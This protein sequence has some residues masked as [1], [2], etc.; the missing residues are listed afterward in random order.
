[1]KNFVDVAH[2]YPHFIS[3]S[4]QFRYLVCLIA[5]CS[6]FQHLCMVKLLVYLY[7]VLCGFRLP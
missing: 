5:W 3:T 4:T 7:D 1:M 2:E 6:H